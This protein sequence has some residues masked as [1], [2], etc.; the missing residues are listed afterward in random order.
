M[1]EK[2]LRGREVD[3]ITGLSRTVRYEL[4]KAG[5][6]PRRRRIS[7]RATGYLASEVDEW[8]RSRPLADDQPTTVTP[9]QPAA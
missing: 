8:I 3:R 2:I 4:E 9:N 5:K 1:S 6:F 7:E